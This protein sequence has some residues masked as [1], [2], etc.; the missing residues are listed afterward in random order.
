[1]TQMTTVPR[2]VAVIMDGNG[3]WAQAQGF[4]RLA[5]HQRGSEVA[6]EVVRTAADLGVKY[7]T[8]FAFSSENWR[9]EPD[10]VSGL[11]ALL[12]HYL[13][14]EIE[15]L[16]AKGVRLRIIGERHLLPNN[17]L[18]L[19]EVSEEKTRG[20][21]KIEMIMALSYGSRAEM[22]NAARLLAQKVKE[23]RLSPE[24]ITEDLFAQHLYTADVPDPDLLIRTSGEQ[25]ISNYLLWQLAYTELVFVDKFW[26]DFTAQDFREAIEIYSRR[27]RR[28]GTAA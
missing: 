2:H 15:T 11:M 19:V 5:G 16:H 9:R 21:Q 12:K 25:R 7:I 20:N 17:I 26:P 4:P 22:V 27:E 1:M 24:E 10:E 18:N 6:R 13:E 3:R 8:L 14:T 28:F 23:H